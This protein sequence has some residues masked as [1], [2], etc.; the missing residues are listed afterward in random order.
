MWYERVE[1]GVTGKYY[2]KKVVDYKRKGALVRLKKNSKVQVK[3][4]S[5]ARGKIL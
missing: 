2:K 3:C 1:V 5:D 4:L